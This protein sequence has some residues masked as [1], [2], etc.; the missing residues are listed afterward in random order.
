MD[1]GQPVSEKKASNFRVVIRVRPFLQHELRRVISQ[2]ASKKI[3]D[4]ANLSGVNCLQIEEV[5]IWSCGV[6]PMDIGDATTN[7]SDPR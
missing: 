2:N 3:Q 7:K 4:Q 5:S 1:S 6:D